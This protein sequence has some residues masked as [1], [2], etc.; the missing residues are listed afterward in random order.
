[1]AQETQTGA[2]NQPIGMGWGGRWEGSSKGREYMYTY[3]WLML[4]FDSKQQKSVKKLSLNKK[5]KIN[6]FFKKPNSSTVWEDIYESLIFT[7]N[8]YAFEYYYIYDEEKY[9]DDQYMGTNI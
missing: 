5:K 6:E 8:I 3:L 4:R 9:M 2:L 7:L 1:M